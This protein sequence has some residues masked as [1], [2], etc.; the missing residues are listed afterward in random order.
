MRRCGAHIA[1]GMLASCLSFAADSAPAIPKD[2]FTPR[3]RSYWAFQPVRRPQTPSVKQQSWVRN[4]VDAFILSKL[5]SKQIAPSAEADRATLLRRVSLD[6]IGLPPSDEEV[7]AFIADRSPKAY[8]TVVDRL[9]AS[10]QYGERWARHW[11]DLARYADSD[12]FKADHTRPNI[13][14]YRDYVI[15]AFNSDKPYD[16]FVREQ[17][18]GDE[19]WPDDLDARIATGF[20]RHYPEEY[21]AQNLR[22]RRLETLNDITDTTGAVFL[23][24]T[25]GCAKCHDHKFDPILQDDYYKLQAFFAN[26]SAVDNTPLLKPDDLAE[27]RRKLAL[28]NEKTQS[29]R[30]RMDA[31]IEPA[32]KKLYQSR[33]VAYAPDVQAAVQKPA[34][35]RTPL[36]RWIVHRT[37]PFLT[38]IDE[39][40]EKTLKGQD[41]EEFAKLKHELDQ[42]SALDPGPL[43]IAQT[44][45]ELGQDPPP[46]SSLTTG[47]LE[48]PIHTVEP[49][50]L[51]ILN[52]PPPKIEPCAR[53]ETSGRRTALANWLADPSNPLTARV[54]VNR[55]W[56][57]HF[58]RGIVATPSD[59]GIMGM[60]PSNPELLDWLADEFVRGGW[61]IKHI[62]RLIVTS[63]AYR[64]TSAFREDAAKVDASN[65]LLWRFPRHHI[66]AE[67]IRDSALSIAGLLSLE[68][69]GPGVY[70]QLP[71]GMPPPRGGW[72]EAKLESER[73]RRSIY[74]F[75]RRNSR[76][77]MLEVFDLASA[78]ET[79]PR[80]NTTTTA[81][82]ALTLL[83]SKLSRDWAEAFAGRV[84]R[85]AG[86]QF[87]AQV[88]RAYRLAYSRPPD[89]TEKDMA[90][91]FLD[92]QLKL[93]ADRDK[94]GEPLSKP[95]GVPSESSRLQAAAL[96][97][98][99]QALLNSNEFVYSN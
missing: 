65:K 5:E 13:W 53:P 40:M 78:Q 92:R 25:F 44:M 90:L 49:G 24:L 43:P 80:R 72:D 1:L 96:V 4:P 73:N 85:E 69:G 67:V 87:A 19:L 10:P 12:G 9:L 56:G 95:A 79:C 15:R 68:M 70:P 66:D 64:Q 61:S 54:M 8:E 21:N 36:E 47:Q 60:R 38:L 71:Q 27:Y 32:R 6:L 88:D 52:V 37:E 97:D 76:Y 55:I 75:V 98:F 99:C 94:A 48:K 82:Q 17:I 26:V 41:K 50:F 23:G 59:F 84:I 51:T 42:F 18:A 22:Q 14:R 35:E 57:E 81:P 58:G 3:Q 7:R 28:W 89:S 34:A 91:T 45:S 74:I 30:S 16:R 20:H 86:P 46:T 39:N 63:N 83:N 11:L 29:I 31:L 77:P 62:Q 93:L 33:F 2:R